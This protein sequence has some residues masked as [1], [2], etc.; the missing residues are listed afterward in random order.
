METESRVI[1][2]AAHIDQDNQLV[3]TFREG[4]KDV[5][6][7]PTAGIWDL[8]Q[9][10]PS[11]SAVTLEV[12][13]F[14]QDGSTY[15]VYGM[16]LAEDG[17]TVASRW[18]PTGRG[19]R[20]RFVAMSEEEARKIRLVIGATPRSPGA[21]VPV[22]FTSRQARSGSSPIDEGGGKKGDE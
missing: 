9:D 19:Q 17:S 10:V 11:G 15:D 21:P 13:E 20:Y 8:L 16:V 4:N 22:P 1:Q 3:P 14:T 7:R 18:E 5:A 12:S 2:L 6:L